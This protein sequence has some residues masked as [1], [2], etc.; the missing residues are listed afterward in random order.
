MFRGFDLH[1]REVSATKFSFLGAQECWCWHVSFRAVLAF[2]QPSKSAPRAVLG[3]LAH[4]LY[5]SEWALNVRLPSLSALISIPF[6][7][8][9]YQNPFITKLFYPKIYIYKILTFWGIISYWKS[10][11]SNSLLVFLFIFLY[12]KFIFMVIVQSLE[13]SRRDRRPKLYHEAKQL[14]FREK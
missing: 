12:E 6:L 4:L 8:D 11:I 9:N 1:E 2:L 5:W 7:R 13:T 14:K 10:Q 3:L